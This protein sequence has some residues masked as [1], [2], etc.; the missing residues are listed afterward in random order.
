M[1]FKDW[2]GL[3]QEATERGW[4]EIRHSRH[5]ILVWPATG[6]KISIPTSASDH[7]AIKNARTQLRRLE[8]EGAS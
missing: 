5:I 6:R 2:K 8:R 4:Q 3:I 1:A 7:R